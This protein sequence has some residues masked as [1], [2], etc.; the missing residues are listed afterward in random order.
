MMLRTPAVAIPSSNNIVE[1]VNTTHALVSAA[2]AATSVII[3]LVDEQILYLSDYRPTHKVPDESE[4][5]LDPAG[6]L[7][8]KEMR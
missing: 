1:A 5:V 3:H 8:A 6:P 2:S 7:P 4:R